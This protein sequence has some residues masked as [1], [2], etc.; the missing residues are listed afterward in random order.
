MSLDVVRPARSF[1][2]SASFA[3]NFALKNHPL[4]AVMSPYMSIKFRLSW[5][6]LK[7]KEIQRMKTTTTKMLQGVRC[8]LRNL[9]IKAQEAKKPRAM[10]KKRAK[11]TAK[12][13]QGPIYQQLGKQSKLAG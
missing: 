8:N 1:P 3:F 13:W 9:M 7:E 2:P 10:E 4:Q 11:A 6:T 5:R 12:H